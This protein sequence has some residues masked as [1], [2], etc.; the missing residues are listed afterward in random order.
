[1]LE[2]DIIPTFYEMNDEQVPE[3][4]ISYVRNTI[5]RIAPYFT[6]KRMIE[7]YYNRFYSKMYERAR[8][9]KENNYQQ[10]RELAGWKQKLIRGWESIEVTDIRMT[11]STRKPLVLGE[12]FIA[13]ISLKLNELSSADLGIEILFGE[14][15]NDVVDHIYYKEE[16]QIVSQEG[17]EVVFRCEIP[18]SRAGVFDYAFRVFPKNP[19]LPHRQDFKLVK[20]I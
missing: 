3:R 7:D 14:K 20:W 6:M 8:L 4:W 18:A 10:A 11:D 16:M 2:E 19:L 12:S 13:E 1:M 9:M 17:G 15:N 5:G